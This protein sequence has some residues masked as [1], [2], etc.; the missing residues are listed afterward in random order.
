[1]PYKKRLEVITTGTGKE[2]HAYID[3]ELVC[4]LVH[5]PETGLYWAYI[6]SFCEGHLVKV[7]EDVYTLAKSLTEEES[8]NE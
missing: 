3:D 1:M 6:T 8:S 5:T 2:F 7:Q 4:T